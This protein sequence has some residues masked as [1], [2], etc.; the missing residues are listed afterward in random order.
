MARARAY[1]C[2]CAMGS[3]AR[4]P[5]PSAGTHR[6]C[7]ARRG[8]RRWSFSVRCCFGA[9]RSPT[10]STGCTSQAPRPALARAWALRP[11]VLFLDEPTASLDPGA[12]HEIE[13]VIA[14]MYAAGT[15]IVLVTHNLGQARRLGDEILFMH[16]G[17][18]AERAA[19]ADFFKRPESPE[20]A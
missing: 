2:G 3:C 9:R 1:Y 5:A 12:A 13:Q 11:E 7:P 4:P 17:R 19:A 15:K 20:A 18:I 6:S 14:A 16:K 10:S 8:A